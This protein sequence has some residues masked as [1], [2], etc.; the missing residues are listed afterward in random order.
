MTI[1]ALEFSSD[2]RGVAVATEGCVLSEVVHEGTRGTPVFGLI[3]R[4]LE[5]AGVGRGSVDALAV[6]LGPG[7]HTGV[8][9]AISVAQGWQLATGIPVIGVGSLEVLASGVATE[10]DVLLAVNSQRGEF[11]VAESRDGA[12]IGGLR[13]LPADALTERIRSG[14]MVAGPDLPAAL[15]GG[16]ARHPSAAILARLAIGRA[17]TPAETLAPVHLREA[18]F[19]KVRPRTP[20]A[21]AAGAGD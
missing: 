12:L 16:R 18:A 1:L 17:P 14:G 19:A 5:Q 7:S 2:R 3:T 21:G 9:L 11:T 13:L 15:S 10:G 20:S 4:V 8:R 6:G